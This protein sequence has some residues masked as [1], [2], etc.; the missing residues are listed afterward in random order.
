ME[1]LKAL[2]FNVENKTPEECF[3][4]LIEEYI[5]LCQEIEKSNEEQF[6]KEIQRLLKPNN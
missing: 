2:G 1:T 4:L 6:K 3:S 5:L